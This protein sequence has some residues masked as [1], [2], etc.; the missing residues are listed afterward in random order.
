MSLTREFRNMDNHISLSVMKLM[1]SE[2]ITAPLLIRLRDVLLP[3]WIILILETISI[4]YQA[5]NPQEILLNITWRGDFQQLA[6]GGFV[7]NQKNSDTFRGYVHCELVGI[8]WQQRESPNIISSS[9]AT[10]MPYPI[11][12]VQWRNLDFPEEE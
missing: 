5:D 8:F 9:N 1:E 10:L 6:H 11:F 3:D 12:T 7:T 4:F 2:L